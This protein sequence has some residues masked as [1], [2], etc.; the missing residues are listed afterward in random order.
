MIAVAALAKIE[1]VEIN[2]AEVI[3]WKHI[4]K[5]WVSHRSIAPYLE[6]HPGIQ[7]RELRIPMW[8]IV[9]N[10][11]KNFASLESNLRRQK[12]F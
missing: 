10:E 4:P 2:G 7:F 12:F 6:I 5:E 11:G 8:K 9:K 1:F 3:F